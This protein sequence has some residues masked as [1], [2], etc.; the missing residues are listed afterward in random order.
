MSA[1]RKLLIVDCETGGLDPEKQSLLSIAALVWHD[2]AIEDHWYGL[3]HEDVIVAEPA[4]LKVNGL[5]LDTIRDEGFSPL[6]AVLEIQSML[7][8]HDMRRDV[9]VCAHNAPFDV[10]YM[11]RLWR[12]A[13]RPYEK[14][15]SYRHLCTQGGALLLEQAGKVTLPGGKASLDALVSFFGIKLNREM[16]HNALADA[17]ACAEVLKKEIALIRGQNA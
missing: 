6:S 17:Y 9:R 1:K 8:K 5:N 13:N 16:G 7:Q 15:F 4:A 3:I 10:G 14:T 11:K 2:G 12:L